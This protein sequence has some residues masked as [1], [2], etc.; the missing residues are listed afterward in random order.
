ME[1]KCGVCQEKVEGDLLV[2]I[3]HTEKHIIDEIKDSH[4]DWVEKNGI[5]RKCVEYYRGQMRGGSRDE[6]R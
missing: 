2:Y 6:G 3:N 5:C 4:P 1:Y